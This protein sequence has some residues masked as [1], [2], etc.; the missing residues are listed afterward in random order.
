MSEKEKRL[1]KQGSVFLIRN[2]EKIRRCK[3]KL[4]EGNSK[5]STPTALTANMCGSPASITSR[6]S[7]TPPTL[8]QHISALCSQRNIKT[9][10][11]V[12]AVQDPE[13]EKMAKMAII[14]RDI[15][16]FLETLKHETDNTMSLV[17]IAFNNNSKSPTNKKKKTL[18]PPQKL[19]VLTLKTVQSNIEQGFYKL[20]ADFDADMNKLFD[21]LPAS[22]AEDEQKLKAMEALRKAYAERKQEVY[23]QLKEL[24]FDDKDLL[25]FKQAVKKQTYSG[26][27]EEYSPSKDIMGDLDAIDTSLITSSNEDIIRCICGL[28]K[29]E[30]LMIQCA[31]CM[32]WQHTEC[33]KADVNADNYLCE[34]CE[35]RKVDRE[36]PL[37]DF[38]EDGHR[39]YLTLMRGN[40]LHVRQGDAVYVLRDI[41][42]RDGSGNVVP[43]Q[44]HTYQ[45]IGDIDYNECDIFRVERLW[46]T[47]EGKRFIFGHH[48]L[49]PHETFHEPTRRFYPN[50]VVRV[51]LYE[52]VPIELVIGRCWVL[53]RTTFIKGR[54]IECINEDH[55][56]ICELRVDKSARFF[57]K[58]K[59][60]YPTCT[61]N[62]AFRKFPEK[63]KISKTYAVS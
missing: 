24:N 2:F 3:S 7:S 5:P 42:I 10:G 9:R 30:G 16:V 17:Q 49:R 13:L 25:C 4:S 41:P 55:C 20:P 61:K 39:Y 36:I 43:S 48:F 46:K 11:L 23:E 58:A 6:R 33:T 19:G 54:P 37:E 56:Y 21:E 12:M 47:K 28:Y 26:T 53:D 32:C 27:A 40:D 18:K 50:E 63:L 1:V 14:L 57:S 15:C 8:A 31:R 60:N 38:T 35:P 34:R 45:T 29:D 59:I 62:Y 52:V 22:V 44:K 51:P